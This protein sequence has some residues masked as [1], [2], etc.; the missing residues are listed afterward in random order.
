MR[1]TPKSEI[2]TGLAC[3]TIL[4]PTGIYPFIGK[5]YHINGRSLVTLPKINGKKTVFRL[6]PFHRGPTLSGVA[7]SREDV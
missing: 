6:L 2:G 3:D 1:K 5:V 4:P 7:R